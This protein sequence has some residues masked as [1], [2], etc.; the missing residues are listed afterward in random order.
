MIPFQSLMNCLLGLKKRV[1]VSYCGVCRPLHCTSHNQCWWCIF[2]AARTDRTFFFLK[3]RLIG[4]C[5]CRKT[6]QSPPYVCAWQAPSR[7]HW[8][9]V[10]LH[11]WLLSWVQGAQPG[12]G[13]LRRERWCQGCARLKV[14]V[15]TIWLTASIFTSF[16][17]AVECDD[18]WLYPCRISIHHVAVMHHAQEYENLA[19]HGPVATQSTLCYEPP[20]TV[21]CVVM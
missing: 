15:P 10:A 13:C 4:V 2:F 11:W 8:E 7:A 9:R 3:L 1:P 16:C 6:L 14:M 17:V 12:K 21:Y 18:L 5:R 19:D 20:A